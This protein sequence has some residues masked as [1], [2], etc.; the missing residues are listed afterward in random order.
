M[1][2]N[3]ADIAAIKSQIEALRRERASLTVSGR[4]LK[5]DSQGAK[6]SAVD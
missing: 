6:I 2:Q 1:N 4:S 5:I 3:Q